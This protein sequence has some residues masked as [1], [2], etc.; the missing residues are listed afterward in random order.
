MAAFTSNIDITSGGTYAMDVTNGETSAKVAT[1]LNGKM[2]NIQKYLQDGLPE[3]FTGSSLPDSLP[4]GKV[5]TWNNNL[6]YGNGSNKPL[7]I[8]GDNNITD[9]NNIGDIVLTT[10]TSLG[11]KYLLC[12]GTTISSSQ[13]PELSSILGKTSLSTPFT[14][15]SNAYTDGCVF[16]NKFCCIIEDTNTLY[17]GE[18]GGSLSS[19]TL[20][21]KANAIFTDGYYLYYIYALSRSVKVYYSNNITTWNE[22]TLPNID[23]NKE[24][25]SYSISD[26]YVSLYS[27]S[28]TPSNST[29]YYWQ[30]GNSPTSVQRVYL[31]S[32]SVD[33]ILIN[34]AYTYLC[35]EG[36]SW[37]GYIIKSNTTFPDSDAGTRT[38]LNTTVQSGYYSN[39]FYTTENKDTLLRP[40]PRSSNRYTFTVNS[41]GVTRL[42]S[43]LDN[44][45]IIHYYNGEYLFPVN[46][47]L[48]IGNS[49]SQTS[50]QI[51]TTLPTGCT[52]ILYL[53]NQYL[54]ISSTKGTNSK[55]LRISTQLP[56]VSI[57]GGQKTVRA[58]IKALD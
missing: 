31:S 41:S 8:V 53:N 48:Y 5:I 25:F 28:D 30:I 3:V 19:T 1:D 56:T 50:N 9:V 46:N 52:N 22:L 12:N 2:A 58:F 4:N 27:R 39:F 26:K 36:S 7:K 11:N 44:C 35:Y 47:I 17:Y 33:A 32:A 15:L 51:N 55:Y 18:N 54:A 37:A 49:V 43:T 14:S 45:G 23:G 40:E 10:K 20:P 16:Q 29:Y 34:S 57:S 42:N 6:Y 24:S 38:N 13:Y 21:T